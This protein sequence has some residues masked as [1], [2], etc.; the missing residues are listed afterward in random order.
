MWVIFPV[1]LG[2]WVL[3]TCSNEPQAEFMCSQFLLIFNRL[4]D[5]FYITHLNSLLIDYIG[6]DVMTAHGTKGVY[7]AAVDGK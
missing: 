7:A 4:S 3:V 6:F 2:A 1:T 5:V